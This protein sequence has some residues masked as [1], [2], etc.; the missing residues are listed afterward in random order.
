MV[1]ARDREKSFVA[2]HGSYSQSIQQQERTLQATRAGLVVP[3]HTCATVCRRNRKILSVATLKKCLA[4]FVP[5]PKHNSQPDV[6]G[7]TTR[8]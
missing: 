8:P 2:R 4:R 6:C 3:E 7:G 5:K 1:L